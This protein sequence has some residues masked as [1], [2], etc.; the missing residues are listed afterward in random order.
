M[1]RCSTHCPPSSGY[2][3]VAVVA[4]VAAAGVSSV[5][6]A[7]EDALVLLLVVAAVACAVGT[8][9][10]VHVLRRDRGAVTT[11]AQLRALAMPSH[12]AIPARQ[13]AAISAA[14]QDAL[15]GYVIDDSEVQRQE[16]RR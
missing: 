13:R 9:A 10:L 11:G 1:S 14:R 16:V 7:I 6:A 5:A 3:G 4:V 15:I 2:A 12:Q 8:I